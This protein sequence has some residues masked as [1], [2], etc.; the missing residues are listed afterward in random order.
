MGRSQDQ[1]PQR[2]GTVALIGR[3]NAGKST[4][5]NRLVGVKLAIVSD[6]PQTTRHRIR[7]VV[8]R[9]CGQVV[10][11]DT[12][13]IH[14]PL[15]RM[16]RRMMKATRR[17]LVDADVVALM[18]D[19]SESLGEGVNY[20]LSLLRTVKAPVFLLL[21]KID[22]IAKPRLLPL[23]DGL[24][25]RHPFEEI[26]PIC[27]LN[28]DN[29]EHF[30]DAVFKVLPVA[31]PAFP[32]DAL[33]DR[34]LRFLVAELVREKILALTRDELPF[35]TAVAIDGWEEPP[36]A[37]RAVRIMATIL[38]EKESQKPIVIG[39]GGR[40]LRQIGT[41]ARREIEALIERH[42]FLDLRVKAQG[43]WRQRRG[44]LDRLEIEA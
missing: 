41:A 19:A 8:T 27:A 39:R 11:L 23:I 34:S 17:A 32:D 25:Q 37:H 4:L 24:R 30:I 42:V 5:L 16:N 13:G 44:V 33:T 18:L 15:F 29:C 7:G 14:K 36:E 6:K 12:P 26:I 22:K 1:I 40:M 20:S 9:P 35:V 2:S 43:D 28:G 10:F 38:V 21:N 3:P 31:E